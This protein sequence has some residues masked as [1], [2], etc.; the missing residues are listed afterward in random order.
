MTDRAAPDLFLI[1]LAALE[2]LADSAARVPL[3]IIVE[4]GQWL[5]RP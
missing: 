5:D 2:L 1:A 4:D 3:L